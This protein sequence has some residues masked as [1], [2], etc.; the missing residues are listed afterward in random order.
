MSYGI[1]REE[2][3]ALVRTHLKNDNLIHH[4]LAAEAVLRAM[5]GRL[6]ADPEQWGLAGLLHDL[7]AEIKPDLTSHTAETVAILEGKGVD[8]EIIEAIRLHNLAAW[9]GQQRSTPFHY[10]L[11]AGETITGLII[12]AAL[13]TPE[14]KLASVK[15]KSVKKRYKEKAFARGADREIIALCELAGIPLADFCELSLAAMQEI[16]GEI[17]L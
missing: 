9:P 10:A 8:G 14:K 6:G 5:A 16:A 12:A 4:S 17:G 1:N 15:V 11:A 2:A 7:D 3:L 13:I